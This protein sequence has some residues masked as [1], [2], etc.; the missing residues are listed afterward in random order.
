VLALVV[1][2]LAVLLLYAR[3]IGFMFV[4]DDLDLVVRNTALHES[5]WAKLL[6]RDFWESTGG[7]TGMWRPLVTLSFRVDGVLSQWQPW[8][9]HAVNVL[10]H[11]ASAALVARLALARGLGVRTAMAAGLVF[12]TAPALA[13]SVAWV[14]GRTDAFLVLATLVALLAAGRWRMSGSRTALAAVGACVACALLAKETALILPLVLAADAA[15]AADAA[16][17]PG[18][19]SP[20]SRAS[21][22]AW[23][24]LV[25]VL[26]WAGVH[27]M[28]I[29]SPT[30]PPAISAAFGAAALVWAHLAWLTP[31]APHSPLLPLWSVPAAP[32]AWAAWLG[33]VAMVI[34]L[35]ALVRR[36]AR[37]ALPIVLLFAPLL[38]VAGASLIEAGVRFA[39]RSLALPAVGLALALPALAIRVPMRARALTLA[40]LL[41]W[42]VAQTTVAVP[43]IAAWRDEE[44]RIRRVVEV[45][46]SDTDAL[47][48]LADLLS[49]M[50]RAREAREWIARAAGRGGAEA[51]VTLASLE[52]RSGHFADA[53][54]AAERA[55]AVEPANLA[56]GVIRVRTLAHLARAPEAVVAGE[57]LLA[58]HPDEAAAQGALGVAW[59]AVGDPARARPL[60]E[61]AS[62]RLGDDAGLAWD[63]GRAAMAMGDV[64]LASRAFERVVTALPESYE[65]WLGVAD[66]R[67]RLGDST[68]AAAALTHAESLPA[69]ADGRARV[70][71]GRLSR[72]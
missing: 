58:A 13:E 56:A 27:R 12:A 48:G 32:V 34:M 59:L 19:R 37:V 33:L 40:V 60:L 15:D 22:P 43:A 66:T 57:A 1:P 62:S 36:R 28:L 41:G 63:L 68:G 11:T 44:S 70:L 50:G 69:S 71:R 38:P 29:P 4:W 14:A 65:G 61:A 16:H 17:A 39:E 31:W 24:A 7:G 51:D 25:V 2:A 3:S 5:G 53:L 8:A 18:A 49:T 26:A 52:Y 35:W 46:P 30:H 6:L 42:V 55:A 64:H 21:A 9:F 45:R 54:A 10:V 23:V 20:R 47:L 67:S 72:H